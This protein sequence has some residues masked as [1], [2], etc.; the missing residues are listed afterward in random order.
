MPSVMLS[1]TDR[2]GTMPSALR[3]SGMSAMPA[4][5]AARTE[6][7]AT[8][9][10][11]DGH[12]AAV[13]AAGR[14]RSPW[15]W[16]SGP[17]RAGPPGPT[18]SPRWTVT[19][20]PSRTCRRARPRASRSTSLAAPS[21]SS[22]KAVMSRRLGDL[23]AEHQ[24]DEA[25]PGQLADRPVVDAPAVPQHRHRVAD[26]EDL[27]QPMGHV[28][29]RHALGPEDLDG[30]E[31]AL[32]LARLEGR[33]RLIHDQHPVLLRHRAGDGNGLLCAQA[34]LLQRPPDVDPDAVALHHPDGPGAHPVEVD[35]AQSVGRLA[36]Q[37]QVAG[38]AQLGDQVDLLVDGA[39]A[40]QLR[41][42]GTREPGRCA[43]E[44]QLAR[45]GLVDPGH[46]LD[47]RRLACA[48]LAHER[49]HLAGMQ[50]HR[51]VVEGE[52]APEALADPLDLEH[53]RRWQPVPRPEGSMSSAAPCSSRSASMVAAPALRGR[54]T[55]LGRV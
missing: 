40:R 37:E 5:M 12:A 24:A 11:A 14:R 45:I 52:D 18:T 44:A 46:D 48:V 38:D 17:T 51:H 50:V 22:R 1:R 49:M 26:P 30:R 20:T 33:C 27:I 31:Q 28:D 32:D 2:P 3:S 41:V 55:P 21:V 36:A 6:P 47:E 34:H 23:A 4:S 54:R 42:P 13:D 7:G 39:D 25:E 9:C 19:S 10:P 53:R 8:G 35:E 29:E 43:L 16:S 15:R